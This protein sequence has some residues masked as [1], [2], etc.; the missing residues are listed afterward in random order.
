LISFNGPAGPDG[1]ARLTTYRN[2]QDNNP[3]DVPEILNKEIGKEKVNL[4]EE[5]N[6]GV[7]DS[8]N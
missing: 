4:P 6:R 7:N 1:R 2:D 5:R 3:S 8:H